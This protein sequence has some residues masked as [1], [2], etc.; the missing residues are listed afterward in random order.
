LRSFCTDILDAHAITEFNYRLSDRR[1]AHILVGISVSG[2]ADNDAFLA[3]MAAKG[4]EH[5]D[6]SNDD[7]AKEHVRH[8]IGGISPNA[9]SEHL[10][11]IN[12]PERPGALGGFLATLGPRWNISAFH[13]RNQAS[14]TG[15]VLIG[16]EAE[17][18]P[19]LEA[20]LSQTGYS[21]H[22]V[23]DSPSVQLFVRAAHPER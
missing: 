16:F 15:N 20:R 3:R 9:V 5:T 7:I 11:Q 2:A 8:M 14:D 10:Y 23:D 1:S 21:R 17:D 4:Y 12:F 6:L 22:R 13:Y 18:L 19:A